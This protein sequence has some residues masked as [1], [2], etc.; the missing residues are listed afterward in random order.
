MNFYRDATWVLEDI[1]KEAAKVRISGS[2]QT[3]VLKS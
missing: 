1:E 2:M 3:L